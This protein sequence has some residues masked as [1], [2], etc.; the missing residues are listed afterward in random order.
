[1]IRAICQNPRD[2]DKAY[3]R[4]KIQKCG[5]FYFVAVELSN[6]RAG[7]TN[8]IAIGPTARAESLRPT[9]VGERI[10]YFFSHL[11]AAG[12]LEARNDELDVFSF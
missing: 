8:N 1:M 2:C 5:I 3:H 12:E 11:L 6:G 7:V 4:V 10:K 9:P